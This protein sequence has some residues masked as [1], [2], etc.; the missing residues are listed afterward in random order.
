M[1]LRAIS[2][3]NSSSKRCCTFKGLFDG[4]ATIRTFGED[5]H[6]TR[7]TALWSPLSNN[8]VVVRR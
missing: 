1:Q 7:G 5:A 4:G 2:A 3:V 6:N 8:F